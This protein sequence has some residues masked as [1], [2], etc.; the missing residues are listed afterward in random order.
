MRNRCLWILVACLTATLPGC[1]WIAAPFLMW[2]QEPTKTV[3]AEYPYL[4][5]KRVAIVVWADNYT[6][7]EYPFVR[8]ELSEFVAAAMKDTI[9]GM[10]L[11]SNRS[12]IDYQ[13]KDADWDRKHAA[14][15]GTR[16]KAD[17]V[18]MIEL[19][20]YTT[21]E[22]GSPHLLRGRISANVKVYDTAYPDAAPA[23][24]T[25]IETMYPQGANAEWNTREDSI[26]QT[27]MEN[28][29]ADLAGK[30]YERKVKV[31]Q[32]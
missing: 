30:F 17:R 14:T 7:M 28:F 19:S 31:A 10:K 11:V 15:I 20:T 2:G 26:R 6:L 4:A 29:A 32:Q 16:F 25:V 22:S 21:R 23:Y 8:L 9:K 24:Q 3:P 27:T 18:L 1:T 13:D 12:V 5:E